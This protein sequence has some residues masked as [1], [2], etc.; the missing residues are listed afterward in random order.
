MCSSK[1]NT[2]GGLDGDDQI[3]WDGAYAHRLWDAESEGIGPWGLYAIGELNGHYITDG[4]TQVFLSPGIQL[5]T[6]NVILEAGVQ[7]PVHQD[8]SSP[9][10]ET[11]FTVVLSLRIRF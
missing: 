3:R 4:S 1:F 7:F 9:R 11:D 10:L 6:S 2:A 5:I 8:L